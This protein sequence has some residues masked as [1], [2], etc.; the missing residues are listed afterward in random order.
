MHHE[1]MRLELGT[2]KPLPFRDA[3][4]EGSVID[5]ANEYGFQQR[6]LWLDGIA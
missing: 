4:I 3:N 1:A 2:P 5:T 6:A